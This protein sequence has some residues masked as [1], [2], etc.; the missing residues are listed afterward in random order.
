MQNEQ[1][2]EKKLKEN[3]RKEQISE[4]GGERG[5]EKRYNCG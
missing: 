2:K 5:E 4:S 1:E 3:E